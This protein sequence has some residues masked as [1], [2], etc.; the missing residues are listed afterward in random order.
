MSLEKK[1]P[2]DQVSSIVELSSQGSSKSNRLTSPGS[3]LDL[4]S[5]EDNILSQE[6]MA[7]RGSRTKL[8][9]K[10]RYG[11]NLALRRPTYANRVPN[12][13]FKPELKATNPA[14]D[15]QVTDTTFNIK[16]LSDTNQGTGINERQGAKINVNTVMDNVEMLYTDGNGQNDFT[17]V[18]RL[19]VFRW[20]GAESSPTLSNILLNP[21]G[22]VESVLSAYQQAYSNSYDILYDQ[23]TQVSNGETQKSILKPY[24]RINSQASYTTDGQNEPT[25]GHIY[26]V[27]ISDGVANATDEN[28]NPID[29]FREKTR[30]KFTD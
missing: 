25:K 1:R 24:I 8:G 2:I 3:A 5:Q 22:G 7:G 16:L 19:I 18:F 14:D 30:V 17:Q 4:N 11:K 9:K 6:I 29:N 13:Y 15:L 27:I 21:L 12:R 10:R 20:K 26:R 23:I 28:G